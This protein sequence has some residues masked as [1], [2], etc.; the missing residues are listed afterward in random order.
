EGAVAAP[1]V[2]VVEVV[3]EKPAEVALA[4]DDNVVEALAADAA[5]EALGERVLPGA[6][7]RGEDFLD[8]HALHPRPERRPV[9]AVPISDQVMRS[10][11]P[12]ER[13]GDLLRGPLR[14]RVLGDV[15]VHDPAPSMSENDED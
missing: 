8:A 14:R 1:R 10:R 15:E 2:V 9:R 6:A 12:G 4:E 3:A 5:D 7:R 11:L 13:F